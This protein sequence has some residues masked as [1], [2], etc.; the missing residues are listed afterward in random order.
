MLQHLKGN[1]DRPLYLSIQKNK[2][3]YSEIIIVKY[4]SY[5]GR[6]NDSKINLSTLDIIY[7]M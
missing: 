1:S 2:K 5:L 3:K 7:I 6:N 4:F